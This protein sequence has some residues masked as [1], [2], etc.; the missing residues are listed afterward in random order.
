MPGWHAKTKQLVKEDKLLVA[1]IAPEQHGDRMK[2]FLQWK[3]MSDMHVM[4]DSYNMLG[5]S[6]VPITLLI[7]EA[8]VI[9]FKNPKDTDLKKFLALPP[10][11]VGTA[12]KSERTPYRDLV[13]ATHLGRDLLD[14][15]F[16]LPDHYFRMG[17]AHRKAYDQAPTD[18]DPRH[19]QR[20]VLY[21]RR[22]LEGNPGNYIWRRRLQQYGPRLDK[23][24][25]FYDWVETARAEIRKRGE[26]PHPLLAEPMGAEIAKP[27]KQAESHKFVHPDPD[28]KLPHDDQG[29]ITCDLV[30]V[31]HTKTPQTSARVLLTL[32]PNSFVYAKWNDEAGV[33]TVRLV[34]NKGWKAS[35]PTILITPKEAGAANDSAPRFVEFEIYRTDD[36]PKDLQTFQCKLFYNVC[37]GETPVCQLFRRDLKVDYSL[38]PKAEPGVRL[39]P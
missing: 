20:A 5:L 10:A 34:P 7:D 14:P 22:A 13:P 8:G 2:L 17:V 32:T 26:K 19:L 21:W 27:S 6:G 9:R 25:P 18:A 28:R 38:E 23:P 1:G 4:L 36:A 15:N 3:G 31:P 35:K 30:V 33:S 24:Y 11:E 37:H 29:V 16:T 39:I 12:P